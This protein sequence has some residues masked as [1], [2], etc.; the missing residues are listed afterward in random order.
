MAA[1]DEDQQVEPALEE[2]NPGPRELESVLLK[3]TLGDIEFNQPLTMDEEASVHDAIEVMQ[4]EQ[5]A[6]IL[7]T[8]QAKLAGIFTHTDALMKAFVAGID[9]KCT[10]IRDLMTPNPVALP[11]DAGVAFALNK[12]AIE[13]FHRVLLVD[14]EGH[15]VGIVSMRNII[16]YLSSLFPKDMLNLP[17]D[18]GKW[19]RKREG[20]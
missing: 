20:A 16:A 3:Q 19:F 13:G 10:P 7:I 5:Q 6:C 11:M 2:D 17:P 14:P 4:R 8:R 9:L 1:P 18:P 15:P 12:M